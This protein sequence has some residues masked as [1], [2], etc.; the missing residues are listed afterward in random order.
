MAYTSYHH[1]KYKAYE[2]VVGGAGNVDCKAELMAK[3]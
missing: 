2:E 1:R 3:F